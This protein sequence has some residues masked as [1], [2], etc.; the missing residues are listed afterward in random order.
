MADNPQD[1]STSEET[2]LTK[3]E[4]KKLVN[5]TQRIEVKRGGRSLQRAD[6]AIALRWYT[7]QEFCAMIGEAGFIGVK[8]LRGNTVEAAHPED[9]TFTCVGRRP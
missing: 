3:S 7:Q 1:K 8:V 5:I 6:G 9:T 2:R 4:A